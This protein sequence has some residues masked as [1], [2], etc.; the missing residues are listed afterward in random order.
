MWQTYNRLDR[1]WDDAGS[2]DSDS[3]ENSSFLSSNASFSDYERSGT[4][5]PVAAAATAYDS[6]IT[7]NHVSSLLRHRGKEFSVSEMRGNDADVISYDSE[8][9]GR[10]PPS[11]HRRFRWGR[12]WRRPRQTR[13]WLRSVCQNYCSD[14]NDVGLFCSGVA[15]VLL[16]CSLLVWIALACIV[17]AW[18][19]SLGTGSK[20]A[21]LTTRQRTHMRTKDRAHS[22][23]GSK[24]MLQKVATH[25][26]NSVHGK[27]NAN[28][29]VIAKKKKTS[30]AL[31]PGCVRADWQELN[32][33]NCNLIHEVDLQ[34]VFDRQRQGRDKPIGIL[35]NGMWRDVIAVDPSAVMKE[36]LV[37]KVMKRVHD[38]DQRNFDRHR[39]DALSMEQLTSSPNIVDIYSF[40][41]NSM[42][43]EFIGNNMEHIFLENTLVSSNKFAT[44]HTERGRLYLALQAARAVRALHELPGGP[45]V[46]ADLQPRQYLVKDDGTV[47]LNDF[48]RCRFMGH[49][50]DTGACCPLHIPSA[51]GKWRSPEEYA[52]QDL[53]EKLDVYSLANVYYGILTGEQPWDKWSVAE[54]K[55]FVMKGTKPFIPYLNSKNVSHT[56]MVLATLT[57]RAYELDPSKRVSAAEIVAT[58]EDLLNGEF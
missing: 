27:P 31:K 6:G 30:E 53:D 1:I 40:C 4:S 58:L 42:L 43:T 14:T 37:L 38:F 54:T 18:G 11:Q 52:S 51:P 46:H 55:Q 56:D 47:K 29:V 39:R 13:Q 5:A 2:S 33:P 17:P 16:C 34:S 15:T 28:D 44:R 7:V 19:N 21:G 20:G 32:L 9:S 8:G 50:Y 24:E 49:R 23:F 3:Q 36:P 22:G 57:N 25:V 10:T 45:I 41:G 35:D 48:N 12:R 26:W